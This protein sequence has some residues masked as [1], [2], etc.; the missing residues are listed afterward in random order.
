M[1]FLSPDTPCRENCTCSR[2]DADPIA[3]VGPDIGRQ[4]IFYRIGLV[5]VTSIVESNA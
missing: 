1:S 5:V 4:D 2:W 3:A